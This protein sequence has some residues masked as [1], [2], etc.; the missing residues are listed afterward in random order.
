MRRPIASALV[1]AVVT[2]VARRRPAPGRPA[3]ERRGAAGRKLVRESR[4]PGPVL[5]SI[6]KLPDWSGVWELD[7]QGGPAGRMGTR[8]RSSRRNTPRRM[9]KYQ[10]DQK[11]RSSI[12]RPIPRIATRPAC[13]RS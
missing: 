11:A 5:N 12:N 7:W 1:G 13:R 3:S 4:G 2:T 6:A 10:A 8:C 9:Q